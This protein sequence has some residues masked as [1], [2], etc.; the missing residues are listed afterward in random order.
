MNGTTDGDPPVPRAEHGGTMSDVSPSRPDAV[1]TPE[2]P[3]VDSEAG[4]RPDEL[5]TLDTFVRARD[6]EDLFGWLGLKRNARS[7]VLMARLDHRFDDAR[8]RG[9]AAG[10]VELRLEP[11]I[12]TAVLEARPVYEAALDRSRRSRGEQA[13]ATW[14]VEQQGLEGPTDLVLAAH[15]HGVVLGLAPREIDALLRRTGVALP[16]GI[17]GPEFSQSDVHDAD[18]ELTR[19]A[20]PTVQSQIA[21]AAAESMRMPRTGSLPRTASM[22]GSAP[23]PVPPAATA[24]GVPLW[25]F[26]L[27]G[28]VVVVALWLAGLAG[29]WL[30]RGGSDLLGTLVDG[31]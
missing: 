10:V 15:T 20:E 11:L 4:L 22:P 7:G 8:Q 23:V 13:L 1:A 25:V 9:D 29:W 3:S 28:A 30:S 14:L 17:Q 16:L 26:G 12:R 6:A 27:L 19:V 2:G 21:A 18:D 31:L 24:S 5:A